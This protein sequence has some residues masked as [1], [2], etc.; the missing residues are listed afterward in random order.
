MIHYANPCDRED[1]CAYR[2][3]ARRLAKILNTPEI[4]DFFKGVALESKHQRLRHGDEADLE[5]D[6]E[7]WYWLVGYLAGKA[8]HAQRSGNMEKFKHHLVSTS[9]V[10]ANWHARILEKS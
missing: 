2:E 6:P 10:L 8:L 1:C 4:D 7:E 9:A 5:K 3:E